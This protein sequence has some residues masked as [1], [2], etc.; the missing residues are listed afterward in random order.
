MLLGLTGDYPIRLRRLPG[1]TD[2]RPGG[3]CDRCLAVESGETVNGRIQQIALPGGTVVHARLSAPGGGY[4]EEEEDVGV[5]DRAV[6]KVQQ[7][8]ELIAGVGDSV[9]A[10][11]AAAGPDEATVTFGVELAAKSGAALA[12]LATGE[13]KASIQVALTWYLKDQPPG[14]PRPPGGQGEPAPS[15]PQQ[16]DP[17]VLPGPPSPAPGPQPPAVGIPAAAT[18]PPPPQPPTVPTSGPAGV[19]GHQ[20]DPVPAPPQRPPAP[21]PPSGPPRPAVAP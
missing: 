12:V 8:A 14:L 4:W 20:A 10:A 17:A 21:A 7:L 15:T 2:G 6:A 1:P 11:A 3:A 16:P 5:G 13:S 9:L 19:R 18:P